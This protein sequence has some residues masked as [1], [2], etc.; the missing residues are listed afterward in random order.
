MDFIQNGC[1]LIKVRGNGSKY[2]R[3]FRLDDECLSM[4]YRGSKK[5]KWLQGNS[6]D[7]SKEIGEVRDGPTSD[8]F[9]KSFNKL[10]ESQCFT[11]VIGEKHKTLDLIAPNENAKVSWVKGLK[12]LLKKLSEA[13]LSTQQEIWLKEVFRQADKNGDEY[14]N[15]KEVLALLKDLNIA[16]DL[17]TA[18]VVFQV[19]N[20]KG[21]DVLDMDEFM[22]FYN[23]LTKRDEI[24]QLFE[25]Y[26]QEGQYWDVS[27]LQ[28]FLK[29]EQ[30]TQMSSDGCMALIE[31]H[32]ACPK[33]KGQGMMSVDGKVMYWFY[34]MLRS[35][36]MDVFNPEHRSIYMDMTQPLSHY[37]IDSSHNTY[38]AADQLVGPSSTEAYIR[39]LKMGCRCVELDCWDGDKGDPVIYHGHTLTSKILFKDVIYAINAYCFEASEYPVILS[40]ENHCSVAQQRLM[41]A[42]MVDIFGDKLLREE[43]EDGTTELPSPEELKGRIVVKAKRIPASALQENDE[44]G[45]YVSDEDESAEMEDESVKAELKKKEEKLKLAKELSDLVI[46]CQ[47]VSFKGF[48][49]AKEN[50]NFK[51]M[52]SYSENKAFG[53]VEN[54]GLD[55]VEH[56]KRQISRIYPGGLRT[57]SSNYDPVPMWMAGNQIVALNY[58][59]PDDSW[60][61]NQGMFENNGRCGYVLKPEFMRMPDASFNPQGPYLPKWKRKFKIK[62]ISGYQLPKKKGD[63]NKSILDPYVKIDVM[64]VPADCRSEK[65]DHIKDNGFHPV[66]DES[67]EFDVH[68]PQLALVRFRVMDYESRSSNVMVCQFC[69]PFLSM[70]SGYRQVNLHSKY[71]EAIWGASLLVHI[72]IT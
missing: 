38:L 18:K 12:H 37:F 43:L 8:V 49:H 41:A 64:G 16:V 58:Q 57:D 68:V 15:L 40:I 25:E 42:Y 52:S 47:S 34:S 46:I 39:A 48:A 63:K 32:E 50:Y 45:G 59:T 30:Y 9:V 51:Q 33:V 21:E 66:W 11:L 27:E 1:V 22:V 28:D 4:Y 26:N 2:E 10:S 54:E 24:E 6:K 71:G 56:N 20:D 17:D 65:T 67:F 35:P 3:F 69:L 44:E 62:I 61:I 7:Q 19:C 5:I 55:W 29:K 31:K 23:M 72:M 13:D 70:Q 60:H 53:L 36:F 14:L